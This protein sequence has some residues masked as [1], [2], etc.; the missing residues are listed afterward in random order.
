MRLGI[1]AEMLLLPLLLAG[2]KSQRV[3]TPYSS[4]DG[5]SGVLVGSV[6][7]G[8]LFPVARRRA[9]PA[10]LGVARARIDMTIAE[11]KPETSVVTDSSGNFRVKLPAGTY[12]ITMPSLHG[13]MFTKDLPATVTITAGQE[14]RLDIHLDTGI[15]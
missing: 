11:E 13:A 15:R 3:T 1:V 2:V 12:K 5:Q 6:T 8:P 10:T 4:D 14:K 9:P 7:K